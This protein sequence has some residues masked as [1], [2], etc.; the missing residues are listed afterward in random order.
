MYA[1]RSYY[2]HSAHFPIDFFTVCKEQQLV[3]GMELDQGADCAFFGQEPSPTAVDKDPFDEIFPQD[4]VV[5]PSFFFYRQ[6]G[7][8]L[9]EGAGKDTDTVS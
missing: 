7:E 3:T 8:A 1:I 4:R 6:V 9:H 2:D 5:H